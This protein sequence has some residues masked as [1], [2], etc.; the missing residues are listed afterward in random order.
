MNILVTGGAG[1]IGS[2]LVDAFVAA[3]HS[4]V[5][6]D[7]LYMGRLENL[8]PKAKFYLLDIRAPEVAKVFEFE[9]IDVVCHQAAQMDVRKSVADP[10]FDAEVNVLGSL[11]LLQNS[12][13]Y[14][15][16]KFLFASTGG[17][18]YGEQDYFPADEDHPTRPVSPYGVTKLTVEK[19][20]FYYHQV[21][22][23]PYVALR[24][25]NVYGPRQNPH[26]EAGVVAIFTEKMLSGQK[27][28]I[29][30]DG[31]QTRDFVYV[32]D[33]VEAN[34]RAL[35]YEKSDIF[36]IGTGI[37][38]DVNTIFHKLNQII[39]SNTPECHGPPKDGEQLRSVIDYTKAKKLLGWEPKVN[40]QRGLQA[41]VDYFRSSK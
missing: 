23:L 4:T 29:N 22:G 8:N 3:G 28:V 2:N 16:K 15:V 24:Y 36:N 37:E 35:E 1:F 19:Y 32:G 40:L 12:L 21:H 25:A 13:K 26:G 27:P 18:I 10:G 34:L 11:N 31:R 17:A 30:G 39:G 14:G 38:T 9:K 20:L 7:N 41:T 6:V 33:V 5:V